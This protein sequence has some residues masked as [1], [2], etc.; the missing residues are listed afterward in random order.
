M[1]G[2]RYGFGTSLLALMVACGGKAGDDDGQTP[3]G[4]GGAAGG[5]AASS[6]GRFAAGGRTASGGSGFG[7]FGGI[8]SAGRSTTGGAPFVEPEC[9]DVEP[10]LGINECDPLS[11]VSQC[12]EGFGCYPYV[13][14]PFGSGCGVQTFGALCRPAGEGAQGASCGDGTAG[15]A[16]GFIC[17]VGALP[18]RHCT[19]LCTFDG[20]SN[21]PPGMFCGDVD[22]P[23]YGVCF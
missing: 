7:G 1:H 5:A 3:Q 18:G 16:P 11:A 23:G 17:V 22:I 13:D 8:G 2:W 9:P 6:G 19:K 10:P 20:P 14:H 12:G 21:C 15:C 4:S